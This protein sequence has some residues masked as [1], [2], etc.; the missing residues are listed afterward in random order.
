MQR[1]W[2]VACV[3]AACALAAGKDDYYQ[4]LGV[5]KTAST[6]EIK[7][8]YRKLALKYHPDKNPDDR[9]AAEIKFRA[10]AEAY[11]VL[12]DSEKR[13]HYDNGGGAGGFPGFGGGRGA[14]GGFPGF[15]D[16]NDI[17]KDFFGTDDPFADFDKIFERMDA[18]GGGGGGG[19]GRANPFGGGGADPFAGMF[20]NVFGHM[21]GM[22]GGMGGGS[23]SFSSS[24]VT[25][26]GGKTVTKS[27][28][29]STDSS[30]KTRR[31]ASL[32]E[33][34][35]GKTRRVEKSDEGGTQRAA[36]V[37]L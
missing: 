31:S 34:V 27:F 3:L 13:R 16:A 22:G 8:A 30:G 20:G 15:R 36:R 2:L 14:G 19:G 4:T 23:F 9:E 25:S 5:E 28:R 17:F 18:A 10:V 37:G 6:K 33:T 32:E 29:S 21:G 7:A 24:T 35:G 12:S 26:A 1:F 11:E